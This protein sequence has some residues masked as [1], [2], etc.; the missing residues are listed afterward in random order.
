MC[1]TNFA[2]LFV[3]QVLVEL[4]PEQDYQPILVFVG[5]FVVEHRIVDRFVHP[6]L[7]VPFAFA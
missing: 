3:L 6:D 1:Q 5:P 4:V 2:L 7:L